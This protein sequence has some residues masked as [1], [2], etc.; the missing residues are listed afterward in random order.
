MHEDATTSFDFLSTLKQTI[1]ITACNYGYVNHLHNF[2]CFMDRLGFRFVVF[3]LDGKR[4]WV[5]TFWYMK[6]WYWLFLART[7]VYVKTHMRS[8]SVYEFVGRQQVEEASSIFRT[9]QFN[10]IG[11]LKIEVNYNL[12]SV[13]WYWALLLLLLI[14]I[15]IMPLCILVL[16]LLLTLNTNSTTTITY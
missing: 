5:G 12:E 10:L 15:I 4:N 1:I 11:E 8:V 16:I 3:A 6:I 13:N 9:P 2:K 7:A 14:I